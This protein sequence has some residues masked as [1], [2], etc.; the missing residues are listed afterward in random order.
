MA[1]DTGHALLPWRFETDGATRSILSAE[2]ESL[3]CDETYYPWCPRED[4]DWH[5]IVRCVNAHDELVAELER[6]VALLPW[7]LWNDQRVLVWSALDVERVRAVL[8]K[9]EAH[10]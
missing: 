2:N 10:V 4:A 6:V 9:L 1:A 3:I 7:P 5:F 8:A